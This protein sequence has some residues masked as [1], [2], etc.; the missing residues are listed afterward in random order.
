MDKGSTHHKISEVQSIDQHKNKR[1]KI[2][3]SIG[4]YSRSAWVVSTH[5]L[6]HWPLTL[7]FIG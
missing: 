1:K 4:T 7:P 2:H 5:A 6:K 3:A